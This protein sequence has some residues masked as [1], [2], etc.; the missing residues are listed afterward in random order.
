[1]RL[2]AL[3]GKQQNAE[4]FR[5][6]CS[7][8][9][10]R[11]QREKLLTSIHFHDGPH[12]LPL[13]PGDEVPMR[14]WYQRRRD[15][16]IDRS[17]LDETLAELDVVW[18]EYGPFD[19]LFGF[20]MG[21]A[22]A[23]I[24]ASMPT[25][26]PGLS[27]IVVSGAPDLDARSVSNDFMIPRELRSLHLVGLDD[28][29]V[30]PKSS[31]DLAKRFHDATVVEHELGHCVPMKALHI[32]VFLDFFR[33]KQ[34]TT[35]ISPSPS[36]AT[37][38]P[39]PAQA[40]TATIGAP[41][42][43]TNT[44]PAATAPEL[45]H[46]ASDDAAQ[47]QCE[48][49]EVLTAMYP[50]EFSLTKQHPTVASEPCPPLQKGDLC[51]AYHVLLVLDLD[52]FE[53]QARQSLPAQWLGQIGLQFTLPGNYPLSEIAIV[54]VTTGKL[55]LHD[56]FS[57]SKVAA[58]EEHIQ[59]A[60]V[61][62]DA[63]AM[64]CI[65]AASEWFYSGLWNNAGAT[66][67]RGA[68]SDATNEATVGVRANAGAGAAAGDGSSIRD[69]NSLSEKAF[70]EEVDEV[71]EAEHIRIAT[72]EAFAAAS[73]ASNSQH[74]YN[75]PHNIPHNKDHNGKAE[76]AI[77][78]KDRDA[79]ALLP[80]SARGVWNYTVGLVGKPSAGKSTFYN[81]V[82]RAALERGGRL[83]AEVAPHPF[84]TIEPNI[85]KYA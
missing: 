41:A 7:K 49:I 54:G 85:G 5:T 52:L 73:T 15:G 62:G 70:E 53:P 33:R 76:K 30:L 64:I 38:P 3:H 68:E 12:L 27:F 8:L 4:V 65:Q 51:A 47:L 63:C 39:P 84:T 17:S 31:H 59:Q 48:E 22:M 23:T 81:A 16:G 21:G 2:L 75:N 79:V 35:P 29:T 58:L 9:M 80:P 72:A 46:C 14:A 83:M 44:R 69:L 78:D 11:A 26:F 57:H 61:A 60:M 36:S 10:T 32:Q 13:K 20:S 6:R 55:T 45:F 19:G 42:L 24:I 67:S 56:G 71:V 34:S 50:T 77:K 66:T 28:R 25:R 37:P 40:E 1:M 43:V 82:T 74:N 18:R